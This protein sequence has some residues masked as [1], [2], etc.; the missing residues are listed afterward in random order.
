MS[1]NHLYVLSFARAA[2]YLADISGLVKCL[3]V[4]GFQR[5]DHTRQVHQFAGQGNAIYSDN[6]MTTI[7]CRQKDRRVWDV[8]CACERRVINVDML[9]SY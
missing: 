9:G 4:H 2:L 1:I 3:L 6:T 7:S 8:L 5:F